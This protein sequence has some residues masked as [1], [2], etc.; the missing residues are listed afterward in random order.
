MEIL[1]CPA[2]NSTELYC[3]TGFYQG[4][5]YHCKRCH[6]TG[7]LVIVWDDEEKGTAIPFPPQPAVRFTIPPLPLWV[8]ILAFVLLLVLLIWG[9]R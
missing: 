8:K 2:C 5:I 4:R 3:E 1:H 9:L 7:P 6:Y